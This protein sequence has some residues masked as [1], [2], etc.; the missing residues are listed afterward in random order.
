M[1]RPYIYLWSLLGF[2][3]GF[4]N[5]FGVLS[6]GRYVSHVT[7]F[8]TQIGIA[9]GSRN[10]IF[11]AELVGFP[12]SF[13]AGAFSNSVL[14]GVRLEKGKVPCYTVVTGILP[15][16]LFILFAFGAYGA[17]GMFGEM[18]IRARDFALLF[19]LSF[20]CGMQNGCFA[21]LTKGSIRTTH[22][23][24]ISTDIGTDL[25]RMWLG[26]LKEPERTLTRQT[27]ISRVMTFC[28]FGLGSIISVLASQHS[29]YH[30]LAVPLLTSFIVFLWV[31]KIEE[32]LS[33]TFS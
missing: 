29:G 27:N 13:I 20:I 5:A 10:F 28:F 25:A 8:G 16:L 12:L 26:E 33:R 6:C 4:L 7:G 32:K 31:W 9:L 24:G 19:L 14:T 17:F 2:Q 22:L 1:R 3:A 18:L 11:A 21:T 30:A 23:T 15:F